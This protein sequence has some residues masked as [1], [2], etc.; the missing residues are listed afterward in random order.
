MHLAEQVEKDIDNALKFLSK[1][2]FIILHDCNPPSEFHASENYNFKL[3]PSQ[4]YWNGTTWKAFAKAR[5]REDINSCCINTDWGLGVITK[6]IKLKEPSKSIN[7]FYE[8]NSFNNNRSEVLGLIEFEE[9]K[10][11]ISKQKK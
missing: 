1:D 5:K 4:G 10:N 6:D 3:S 2:G 8:Y 11:I 9:F 7:P